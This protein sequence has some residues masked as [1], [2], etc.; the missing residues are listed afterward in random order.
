M[1]CETGRISCMYYKSRMFIIIA[2]AYRSMLYMCIQ[3]L[4]LYNLNSQS[5]CPMF[6]FT[7]TLKCKDV[8][9]SGELRATRHIKW[10]RPLCM[11]ALPCC[12]QDQAYLQVTVCQC[13][14][15][16]QTRR[17]KI[18]RATLSRCSYRQTR[19]G[20]PVENI[21]MYIIK[22]LCGPSTG[23]VSA[24]KSVDV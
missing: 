3:P 17:K 19:V 15:H 13:G 7:H 10:T 14:Q 24:V 22:P 23:H 2:E 5:C 9:F 18:G 20:I 8:L 6:F 16:P 1:S 21:S 11:I 12:N 4:Q